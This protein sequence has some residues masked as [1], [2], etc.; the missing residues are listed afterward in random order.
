MFIIVA[1][2]K[3]QLTFHNALDLCESN[4]PGFTELG[5]TKGV[6]VII[7]PSFEALSS[8]AVLFKETALQ[9]GAQNCSEYKQGAYTG[10]V[11]SESLAEVGCTYCI[12]GHYESR[13]HLG[14]NDLEVA[15]K[16]ERLLEVGIEPIVCI[17]ETKQEHEDEMTFESL[18][19]QLDP[20][21]EQLRSNGTVDGSAVCIAYEPL[22]AIGTGTTA[23]GQYLAQVFTWLDQKCSIA[24]P[25]Y[26]FRFLYGGS[27]TADTASKIKS[28]PLVEGLLIG[29]ASLDFKNFQKIVSFCS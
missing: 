12:I 13:T 6:E 21:I 18:S 27:V 14:E 25:T 11:L 2:W 24:L 17:G 8:V 19:R 1:N 15:H 9:I 29:S 5:Y 16:A 3:S 20:L 23:N 10:Q 22:W 7:C 28:I 4:M 26:S